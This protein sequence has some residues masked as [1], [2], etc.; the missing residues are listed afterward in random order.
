MLSLGA[1]WETGVR[2]V[3]LSDCL[4]GSKVNATMYENSFS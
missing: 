3:R 1:P 2:R 4:M